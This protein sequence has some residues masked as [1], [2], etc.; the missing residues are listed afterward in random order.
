MKDAQW[1]DP[2]EAAAEALEH[3]KKK[4][5]AGAI[6]E[7]AHGLASLAHQNSELA[8]RVEELEAELEHVRDGGVQIQ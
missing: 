5:E 1:V 3:L 4:R 6:K 7:L 2:A 8:E